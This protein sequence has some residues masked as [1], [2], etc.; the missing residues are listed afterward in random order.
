[1]GQAKRNRES[2]VVPPNTPSLALAWATYVQN[3]I[4]PDT[5]AEDIATRRVAFFAGASVLLYGILKMLDTGEEPT[6]ADLRR[7]DILYAEVEQFTETFDETVWRAM[8]V[9]RH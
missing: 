4:P 6:D 3:C 1:M 8:G 9:R 5:A 7:M 2:G